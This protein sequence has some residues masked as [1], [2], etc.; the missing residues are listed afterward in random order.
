MNTSHVT[1][2]PVS[3]AQRSARR[4]WSAGGH[5]GCLEVTAC[6]NVNTT[7]ATTGATALLLPAQNTHT[8]HADPICV[9]QWRSLGARSML[10]A[11]SF[12]ISTLRSQ[13]SFAAA[14]AHARLRLS[15]VTYSSCHRGL[16]P[17]RRPL[18]VCCARFH[19]A[20][21]LRAG[22]GRRS[23]T[24]GVLWEREAA[25]SGSLGAAS[26]ESVAGSGRLRACGC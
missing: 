13:V 17:H 21:R 6:V 11:R 8:L 15:R 12:M 3:V 22:A 24:L 14:V 5:G 10:D 9:R 23:G 18:R 19:F 20:D 7:D 1:R 4:W 26:S 2:Y 25:G 16:R